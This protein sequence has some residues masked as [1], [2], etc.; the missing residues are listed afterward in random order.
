MND[1]ETKSEKRER[2]RKNQRKMVVRGRSIFTIFRV[3]I[4][5]AKDAQR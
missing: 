1:G 3:K 2:I 5:K 4:L